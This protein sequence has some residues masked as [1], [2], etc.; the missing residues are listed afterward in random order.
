MVRWETHPTVVKRNK[1]MKLRKLHIEDYKM[2]KDL[3]QKLE[4]D[5]GDLDKDM[6]LS[7]LEIARIKSRNAKS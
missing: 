6:V 2:F 7:R 4:N 5:L 1:A 3:Y